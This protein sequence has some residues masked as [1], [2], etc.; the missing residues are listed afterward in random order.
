MEFRVLGEVAMATRDGQAVPLGPAKRRS[1]LAVLLLHADAPVCVDLLAEAL[2]DDAPPRHARTVLQGHVSRLRAL[3]GAH[4]AAAAGVELATR[5]TSYVLHT[6]RNLLDAHRFDELL[7][8]AREPRDPAGSPALLRDALALWRGPALAGTAPTPVLE[9]AGRALEERRLTAVLELAAA[10]TRL[11]E[12]G[13]AVAVLQAEAA[14]HPLREHVITALVHALA[15]AD[16]PQDARDL[17]LRT[18]EL[19]ARRQGPG[20]GPALTDAYVALPRPGARVGSGPD[21]ATAQ[22]RT[23]TA[24][25][26]TGGAAAG[27][28]GRA[29]WAGHPATAPV[30]EAD[31]D[32]GPTSGSA[33]GPGTG[34]ATGTGTGTGTDTASSPDPD[35]RPAGNTPRPVRERTGPVPDALPRRTTGFAGRGA[36]LAA[37]DRAT[38]GPPGPLA[39]ITGGAGVGKT[40]LAVHWAHLR[41]DGFP[42]GRLFA[43]LRGYSPT[44]PRDT[45]SVLREFLLALGVPAER[46]PETPDGMAARYRALTA[47]RRML[48]VL[49]NARDSGQ[50]R[51]LLPG[52]EHCVTLVTSRDR[53]AGLVASDA[54]RPLA[55]AALPVDQSLAL[56]TAVLGKDLVEAEAES[57]ARVVRLCDG[58]PLA[59]RVVAARVA[60]R[61]HGGLARL[62]AEL[63]D[64]QNRLAVLDLEDTGVAAALGLS[65]QHLSGPA[66]RMFALLGLLTGPTLDSG[67]A[68]ALAGCPPRHAA[69]ALDRLASANLLC[70]TGPYTYSVH[71]LVRLFARTVAPADDRA[72]LVRLLDHWL[73]T[74]LAATDAA[75]PGSERCCTLPPTTRGAGTVR[76]FTGRADALAWYAAE[77]DTLRGAVAAAV[78][79]RLHGHAWRLVLLQWPLVLW[80][81]QDGWVPLLEQ[82]LVSAEADG[83]PGSQS[84]TLALLGWV[85]IEEGR[86]ERALSCLERAPALAAQAGD[87]AAEAIARINLALALS[88]QGRREQAREQLARALA[89]AQRS[90][91]VE[92]VTLA[93]LHLARHFLTTGSYPEAADQAARGLALAEPPVTAPRRVLLRTLHGEA[94]ARM[95]RTEDAERQLTGAVREAAAHAYPEGERAARTALAALTGGDGNPPPAGRRELA[96]R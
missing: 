93:H 52:G 75:E 23:G 19:L 77:R 33:P 61:P 48:V 7:G 11:G 80:Q 89:Q 70:P 54:A 42:D 3:L 28:T 4:G 88:G 67:T 86:P 37:L 10:H 1:V 85:L 55:L 66:R 40:A 79:A 12:H 63:A 43:D 74:L 29:G 45:T 81:A 26:T 91:P 41:H 95:G 18:R 6:P 83:D 56:L 30:P 59:L 36:E 64:E 87:E 38:A 69:A 90:G 44:P 46:I 94:L 50:V 9:S 15:R 21:R 60:T 49:D 16:R 5:G 32:A 53:L 58:L 82:G 68:A 78:G 65:V 31:T 35:P 71:D 92:T 8:Q 34:T 22:P 47:G 14:A 96:G 20:P 25:A 2:W 76:E 62:G 13:P 57:A 72:G 73:H 51:P 17:F 84:R 27:H 24:L 39:I